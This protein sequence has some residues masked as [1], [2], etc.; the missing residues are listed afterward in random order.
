MFVAN[1]FLVMVVE[2]V[3]TGEKKKISYEDTGVVDM[4]CKPSEI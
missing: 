2:H 3:V 1:V 4:G